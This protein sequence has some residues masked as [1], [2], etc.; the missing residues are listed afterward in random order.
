[1]VAGLS[2]VFP[3][4]VLLLLLSGWLFLFLQAAIGR[5]DEAPTE[6][7]ENLMSVAKMILGSGFATA[8]NLVINW[9]G[10]LG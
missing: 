6:R 3:G 7:K 5:F 1:V 9:A 2:P 8:G 4:P 10:A